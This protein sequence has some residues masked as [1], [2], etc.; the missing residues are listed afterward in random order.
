MHRYH[1][2]TMELKQLGAVLRRCRELKGMTA[3][4]LAAKTGVHRNTLS[5]YEGGRTLD[6]ETFIQLCLAL[7]VDV[8]EVF[9]AACLAKLVSELRPIE[10]RK[11]AEMGLPA[12]TPE[13]TTLERH[14]E[15]LENCSIAL[16]ELERF[17]FAQLGPDSQQETLIRLTP[18][19][20]RDLGPGRP[21]RPRKRKKTE[22]TARG[23]EGASPRRKGGGS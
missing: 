1:A 11:R 23:D 6:D 4:E 3:I 16:K 19:S 15:L 21:K 18:A 5:G 13:K 17:K 10:D 12:R 14:E 9:S 8:S 7:G 22:R 2:Q 20:L